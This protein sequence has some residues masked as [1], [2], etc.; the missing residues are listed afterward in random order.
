M[1][2]SGN[3]NVSMKQTGYFMDSRPHNQ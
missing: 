3:K 1:K 2:Y